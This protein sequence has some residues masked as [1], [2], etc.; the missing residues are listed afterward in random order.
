M[1]HGGKSHTPT[2]EEGAMDN[3]MILHASVRDCIDNG[4]L[5]ATKDSIMVNSVPETIS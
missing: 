3:F 5:G 1:D 2:T 4:E